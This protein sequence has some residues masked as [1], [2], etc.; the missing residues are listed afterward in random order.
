MNALAALLPS[1]S[2]RSSPCA[3]VSGGGPISPS[4]CSSLSTA[5][6]GGAR[7]VFEFDDFSLQIQLIHGVERPLCAVLFGSADFRF[8]VDSCSLAIRWHMRMTGIW[9]PIWLHIPVRS[10]SNF[11]LLR[12]LQSI[13]DLNAKVPNSAFQLAVP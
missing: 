1:T 12:E 5:R 3:T 10:S 7:H 13:F 2:L 9:Q 6:T 11:R 4:P 8:V